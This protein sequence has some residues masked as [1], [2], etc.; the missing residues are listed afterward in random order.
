MATFN[1][2][3]LNRLFAPGIAEYK[4]CDA[5]DITS[6]HPQAEHWLTNHFLNSMLRS[7]FQGRFRQ[8][9]L[10]QIFRAQ[11]AFH[12]YHEAR[13]LTLR[14]LEVS[15]PG[16]P[17][18]RTYFRAISR[19]ESCLL[20]LQIFIDVMNQMK[21]ELND[22]PVF[23]K[24]D[25]TPADMAYR[26]ANTIKHWGGTIHENRH[27]DSDTIPLWLTDKGLET[28]HAQLS[29]GDLAALISEIASVAELLQDPNL[30]SAEI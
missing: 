11:T 18:S 22:D 25:G 6:V 19:W 29:C 23:N 7:Q 26:M 30:F 28:R 2:D 1:T 10:N 5:P 16:N 20:N 24:G 14:F 13:D 17:A 27:V 15:N 4:V 8:Y 21:R 9:A 3:L 12:D